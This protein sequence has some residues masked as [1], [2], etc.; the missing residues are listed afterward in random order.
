MDDQRAWWRWLT[1]KLTDMDEDEYAACQLA[2]HLAERLVAE[3]ISLPAPSTEYPECVRW[4]RG[5]LMEHESHWMDW[6]MSELVP[7]A[8]NNAH[9]RNLSSKLTERLLAAG[10]IPPH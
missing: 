7:R 8:R 3:A 10:A 4:F 9:A 6:L 1:E 2:H 5:K